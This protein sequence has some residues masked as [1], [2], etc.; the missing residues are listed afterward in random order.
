MHINK[1]PDD[2]PEKKKFQDFTSWM[3]E[4]KVDMSNVAIIY[5]NEEHREV[6][7]ARDIKK[8]DTVLTVPLNMCMTV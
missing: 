3:E 6:H 2:H 1:L 8:G 5:Q 7:A 4:G